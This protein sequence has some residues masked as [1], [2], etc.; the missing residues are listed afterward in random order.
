VAIVQYTFTHK[1]I[2]RTT[3]NKQY[4]ENDDGISNA[5]STIGLLDHVNHFVF[6]GKGVVT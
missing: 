1:K 5:A 6:V 4:I 2:H 3:Q